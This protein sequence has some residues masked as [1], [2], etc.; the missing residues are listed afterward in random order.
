MTYIYIYYVYVYIYIYTIIYIYN[1]IYIYV[2]VESSPNQG[3]IIYTPWL[4][5]PGILLQSLSGVCGSLLLSQAG[6]DSLTY[7]EEPE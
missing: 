3:I 1:Y 7:L 5:A 2:Y 4:S 6:I